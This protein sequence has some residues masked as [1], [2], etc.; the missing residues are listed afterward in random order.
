MHYLWVGLWYLATFFS[1]DSMTA[2]AEKCSAIIILIVILLNW[3]NDVLAILCCHYYFFPFFNSSQGWNVL[4]SNIW[5]FVQCFLF[6]SYYSR[7]IYQTSVP[8]IA[9]QFS[10]IVSI[11]IGISS[12]KHLQNAFGLFYMFYNIL[13]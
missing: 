12:W 7:H 6:F 5:S 11:A 3:N 9:E 2:T 8:I 1:L 13:L 10:S 4:M